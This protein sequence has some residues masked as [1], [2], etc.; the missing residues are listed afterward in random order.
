MISALPISENFRGT[1]FIFMTYQHAKKTTIHNLCDWLVHA[2][3][4]LDQ[5]LGKVRTYSM[6]GT[7][8]ALG[9]P[10]IPTINVLTSN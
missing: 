10:Q 2:S 3:H 7:Q 1:N 6:K 4:N 5:L 8:Y 9:N